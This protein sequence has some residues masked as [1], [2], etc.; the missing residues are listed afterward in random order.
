[1]KIWDKNGDREETF[2]PTLKG[3]TDFINDGDALPNRLATP[4]EFYFGRIVRRKAA[5]PEANLQVMIRGKV[6]AFIEGPISGAD[7]ESISALVRDINRY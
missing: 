6:I 1:M 4:N 7:E 3:L 2:D 5:P